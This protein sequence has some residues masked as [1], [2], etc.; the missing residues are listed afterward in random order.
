MAS[1]SHTPLTRAH[2]FASDAGDV[3]V[4][5]E[6]KEVT[7]IA[8]RR[9]RF[10]AEILTLVSTVRRGTL[11]RRSESRRETLQGPA[12]PLRAEGTRRGRPRSGVYSGFRPGNPPPA[13]RAAPFW[14]AVGRDYFSLITGQ[15]KLLT[16]PRSR[17][18]PA[19][20]A[21]AI[22]ASLSNEPLSL[23]SDAASAAA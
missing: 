18:V 6:A 15:T 11:K 10:M 14:S 12:E 3:T 16:T 5:E 4:T 22:S 7:T 23:A 13:R 19:A 2:P 1:P 8:G 21:A 17:A 20:M 9:V